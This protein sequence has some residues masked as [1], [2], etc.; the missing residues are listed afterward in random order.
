MPAEYCYVP[1]AYKFK[2]THNTVYDYAGSLA[3]AFDGYDAFL[4][5][6]GRT[7]TEKTQFI[8]KVR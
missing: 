3:N 2:K 7:L 8:L 5:E 1:Y 4:N 6:Y